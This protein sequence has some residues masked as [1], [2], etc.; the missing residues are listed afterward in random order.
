MSPPEAY[1]LERL[2]EGSGQLIEALPDDLPADIAAALRSPGVADWLRAR[3]F[4]A[5]T[6]WEDLQGPDDGVISVPQEFLGAPLPAEV[7]VRDAQQLLLLYQRV[8]LKGTVDQQ[9]QLLHPQLLVTLWPALS[10]DLPE[11]VVSVWEQ[12]FPLA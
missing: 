4:Q 5:V 11:P 1:D 3:H 12:R 10:D 9:R 2:H 7:T 8:L 6:D